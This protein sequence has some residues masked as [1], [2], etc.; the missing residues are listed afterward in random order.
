M[1]LDDLP[2]EL[3]L[4]I[5]IVS[6]IAVFAAGLSVMAI[7]GLRDPAGFAAAQAMLDG[8][9]AALNTVILVTSGL[10]AARAERDAA[11]GNARRARMGLAVA[12]AGG[13]AF[14]AIKGM[15]YARDIGAGIGID[16]HPFFTFYYLLTGFHAAHVIAG[17]AVLALVSFR[18][19]RD[20]VQ[21]AAMFWHMVDLVWVLILPPVYLLW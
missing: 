3:I 15:E 13:I 12:A 1:R 21:A 6:E 14:L 11:A 18:A 10:F 7:L 8:R 2:G 4:W 5:L 9:M 20:G 19:G 16:T 17:V